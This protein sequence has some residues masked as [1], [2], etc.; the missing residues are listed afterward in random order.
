MKMN[1]SVQGRGSIDAG[2]GEGVD[3]GGKGACLVC[4]V[5]IEDDAPG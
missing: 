2:E 4:P 5:R 1:A 3:T